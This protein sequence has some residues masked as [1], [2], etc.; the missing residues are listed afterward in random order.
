MNGNRVLFIGNSHTYFNDMPALFADFWEAGT[1]ESPFVTMLAHPGKTW[2][3]HLQEYKE[4]RF[5]LLYGRYDY[6]VLQQAAHP[7]P[8]EEETLRDGRILAQ[9]CQQSG[10]QPVISMTWAEKAYPEHQQVM[11]D[12]YRQLACET[13][14]I[15]SPVGEIWQTA[16]MPPFT[17][18]ISL[19]LSITAF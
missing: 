16:N 3:W 10:T 17:E 14:A 9:L 2:E 12:T 8:G 4:V 15:L 11:V 19:P 1:V 5:N 6:C 7:F 18:I 13:G